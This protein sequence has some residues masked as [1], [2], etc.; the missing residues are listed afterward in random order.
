M[1]RN[2]PLKVI[3]DTNVVAYY[4]LAGVEVPAVEAHSRHEAQLRVPARKRFELGRQVNTRL[5]RDRDQLSLVGDRPH[6]L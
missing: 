4:L 5:R 6:A 1:A 2:R 3:V